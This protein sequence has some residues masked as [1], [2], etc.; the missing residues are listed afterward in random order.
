M[1]DVSRKRGRPRGYDPDQALAKARDVFWDA[2]Y[3]SSSLDRLSEATAMNRPS[4]YAAFGD[5]EAL[6]LQTLARYRDDAL[7]GLAEALDPA[8]PVREGLAATYDLALGLYLSGAKGARGCF[9]IGTAAT[10]AVDHPRI[11]AILA[12]SLRAFDKAI[13]DRLRMAQAEGALPAGSDPAALA[14][15]ASAV[16]HSMAVR[17]RAGDPREVLEALAR[18]G[19]DMICGKPGSGRA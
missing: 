17:A 7:A 12:D 9:L 8:R 14:A 4:L 1:S 13:E 5:K 6:Y 15:L 11:K 10:E 16:M 19:I 18:S 2:G 3:S